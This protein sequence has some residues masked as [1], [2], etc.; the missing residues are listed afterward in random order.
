[1]SDCPDFLSTHI[2]NIIDL[3][4]E[5]QDYTQ[6]HCLDLLSDCKIQHFERFYTLHAVH[7]KPQTTPQVRK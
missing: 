3:Y 7:S 1:M 6:E 2:D 4:I 5:L